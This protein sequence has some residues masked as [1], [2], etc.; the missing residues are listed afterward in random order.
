[1][2]P[3][4]PPP[5][6]TASSPWWVPACV[7]ACLRVLVRACLRACLRACARCVC[8]RLRAC[9]CV[10][11]GDQQRARLVSSPPCGQVYYA[12]GSG[13]YGE[14]VMLMEDLDKRYVPCR[15]VCT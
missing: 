13:I 1:M 4:T 6:P 14:Y 2:P 15:R 12:Y 7:R 11:A 9:M 8:V 3:P 5:F 10:S